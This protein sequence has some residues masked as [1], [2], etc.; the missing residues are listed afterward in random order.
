[1]TAKKQRKNIL[2]K[3]KNLGGY[4]PYGL[5]KYPPNMQ[6]GRGLPYPALHL[7]KATTWFRTVMIRIDWDYLYYTTYDTHSD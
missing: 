5:D 1:M 3:C 7:T 4:P 2:R 6:G